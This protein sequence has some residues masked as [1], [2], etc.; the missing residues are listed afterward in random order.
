MIIARKRTVASFCLRMRKEKQVHAAPPSPS[1]LAKRLPV[2]MSRQPKGCFLT[3][4]CVLRACGGGRR[5]LYVEAYVGNL[6]ASKAEN[7]TCCASTIWHTHNSQSHDSAYPYSGF[8]RSTRTPRR[9][10]DDRDKHASCLHTAV[11]YTAFIWRHRQGRER[12]K[13]NML[14]DARL[15]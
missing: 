6:P 10:T 1:P 9:K 15:V 12:T 2:V 13:Y 8:H 14:Q 3:T 5:Y 11:A 4:P 7:T